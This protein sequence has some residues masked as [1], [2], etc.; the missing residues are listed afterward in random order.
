MRRAVVVVSVLALAAAVSAPLLRPAFERARLLYQLAVASPP[1]RLR[2]PVDGAPARA[3]VNTWA[4]PRSGGR[5]HEGIDIFAPIDT[6]VVSTTRGLVTQVGTNSLGGQVVWILG[7]G[8]E[9]HYYAHLNRF[10]D[11]HRGDIINAGDVVGYVGRT[12]NAR[13]TPFHLHYGIYHR[14]KAQ[15]PYP[16]LINASVEHR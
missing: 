16:R 14:G 4:A 8:L 12:G 10:A 1:T 6:P 15:N 9:S 7:P 5:R 2:N 13:G 11:I 3:V